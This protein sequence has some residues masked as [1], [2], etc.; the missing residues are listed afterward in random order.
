MKLFLQKLR[1]ELEQNKNSQYGAFYYLY[2]IV[3]GVL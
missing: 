3:N 2:F 1:Q